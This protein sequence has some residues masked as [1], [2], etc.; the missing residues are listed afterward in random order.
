MQYAL[1]PWPYLNSRYDASI[2][3]MLKK[4][5][6]R[7]AERAGMRAD[8]GE[9]RFG[10][11]SFL[12]FEAEPP[13]PRA[14]EMLS[15][16]S[17][18]RLL[19]EVRPD[20]AMLPLIS[21][22]TPEVGGDLSS[23]IKYKGKTSELFTRSLISLAVLESGFSD[24]MFGRLKLLDPMCGRGTTLFEALNRG[25][26][27]VGSDLDRSGVEQGH[28]FL[29]RYLELGRFKHEARE[30]SMTVGNTQV[31]R[32]QIA[33]TRLEGKAGEGA[34]TAS[35]IAAD[36]VSAADAHRA[37]SFHLVV[38]DLPYGVQHAPGGDRT[39]NALLERALPALHRAL[40]AGGAIALAF[41][42]YTLK[43]ER[44]TALLAGAG[45]EPRDD[46]S[47]RGL[48]HWVE[49]AVRRDFV[50]AVKRA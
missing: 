8:V 2:R 35:F 44:V 36:L 26:N 27:A 30:F 43:R 50:V 24:A 16:H 40:K 23:I 14:L 45:F 17:H 29:K 49:Q 25:W 10:G 5:L 31:K 34:L 9:T 7:L 19:F 21:A 41:N 1:L 39:L 20:G 46:E 42:T 4:E 47:W 6:A 32:R 13:S 28:A 12:S 11:L 37:G 22:R 18:L 48:D 38:C 33:L 15:T 3:P